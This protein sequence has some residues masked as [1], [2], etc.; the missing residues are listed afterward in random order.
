MD[1]SPPG[2]SS[3]DSPGKN[4]GVGGHSL[5]QEI[6]LTQRLSLCLLHCRQILYHWATGKTLDFTPSVLTISLR[7][8]STTFLDWT[9]ASCVFI[10]TWDPSEPP[11]VFPLVAIS[12]HLHPYFKNINEVLEKVLSL[13]AKLQHPLRGRA[14]CWPLESSFH[15][16]PNYTGSEGHFLSLGMRS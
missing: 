2:S 5:L 8:P 3:M 15:L 16:S 6:F 11:P 12:S 1:C 10:L 9:W 4:T 13:S 14:L 7:R